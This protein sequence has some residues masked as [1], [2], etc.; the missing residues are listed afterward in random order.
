MKTKIQRGVIAL[1][2]ISSLAASGIAVAQKGGPE[3]GLIDQTVITPA[4]DAQVIP[5][6]YIV[7]FKS[8]AGLAKMRATQADLETGFSAKIDHVYSAAL[9][10]FAGELSDAALNALRKN[11]DVALIEPD[12]VVKLDPEQVD[13]INAIN[14]S[15]TGA[16]WGIDRI[17]QASL[18]L[19]STYTYNFTGAGV[20]A[21]VIDTGIRRTHTQF[22]GRIGAGYDAVTSGG[23]GEDC[24]GHG[25]HVAGTIGGT[26]YG[27][28]KGVTLHPVRVLDCS[29][30]GTNSGVIAGVDWVR[31]NAV[32]PA[33]ANMSLGGSV[34]SALDTAV[35]NAIS[36]GVVFGIAG[37]N[38]NANACNYS[39]A[40]V[41]SAITVGATDSADA[42]ASYSNYGTCLD[43]FAPGSSITSAWYTSDTAINTISGTSMATPHLVGVAALYMQQF[44]N[45][46]AQQ[47]R[48]AIVAAGTLNK[49]TSAGTG[50]PNVLLCAFAPSNCSGTTPP[51]ATPAPTSTPVGP[52][53]TPTP[54]RTPAPG[55]SGTFANTG[56]ITIKDNAASSPNPSAITVSG[57]NGTVTKVVVRLKGLSH[58]YP[59]DIDAL[60]VGPAGQKL[61]L[62]SDVGGSGDANGI[63]LTFDDA[64][65]ASLP[66]SA[67]LVSGT[68][69]PT[70]IGTGDTFP[71]PAPGT[72][73]AA[74]LSAFNG[75]NPNGSWQ[76]FIKD[77]AAA[78]A[79]SISG[80]WELTI[81]TGSALMRF[82]NVGALGNDDGADF[83]LPDLD[84]K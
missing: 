37:G 20:H 5:G 6:R 3:E 77:D 26:T 79:G 38:S 28:A 4:Q 81:S 13:A 54:T 27:V 21:Y 16:T 14:T 50:S 59:D 9:T 82:E 71:A 45:A 65:A 19:N 58:T 73:Y 52:T 24:N 2:V 74:A 66:D 42:R 43:I 47:A 33:V 31:L 62:M 12:R 11:P 78:D 72:P 17:D 55:G 68:F 64:A 23:L 40:R 53:P 69:K 39:P 61:L 44:P 41:P 83:V 70:N 57:L 67:Q 63:T 51:T 18:P 30:S 35:A 36:S 15:Q 10:G 1:A 56:A 80:G 48:D 7:V 22:T 75:T 34:S 25:T 46:T 32:K 60:V 84:V 29:G 8:A 76:L 49:V